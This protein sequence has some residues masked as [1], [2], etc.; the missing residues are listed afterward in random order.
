MDPVTRTDEELFSTVLMAAR[1]GRAQPIVTKLRKRYEQEWDDPVAGFPYALAMVALL[2]SGRADQQGDFDYTEVVETLTDLLYHRPEHWLGRFLRIQTRTLL[3][4][5]VDEHRA[6]IATERARATE[7][8]YELI[9]RQAAGGWQPWYACTYLLAARL[10]WEADR[11]ADR[12][13][14]FVSAAAQPPPAPILFPSLG[15]V[16]CESFVWYY[17][18][19]G[20]PDRETVGTL[21]DALFPTQ[22]AVRRLRAGR[23]A[24]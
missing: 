12:V 2:L 1:I 9:Q 20:V 8:A 10:A 13:A 24:R 5:D 22:S 7:D 19:P 18:E 11:D 3:P 23:V 17:N 4:A 21:M 15:G 14:G 16:M 6:Y